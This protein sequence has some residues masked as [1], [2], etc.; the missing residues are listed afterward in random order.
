MAW[1]APTTKTINVSNISTGDWNTYV[2]DNLAALTERP[3]CSLRDAATSDSDQTVMTIGSGTE[4]AVRWWSEEWDSHGLHSTSSARSLVTCPSGWAGVYL[5]CATVSFSAGDPD[6]HRRVRIEVNGSQEWAQAEELPA[7]GS[8]RTT[9]CCIALV[10]MAVGDYLRVLAYQNSGTTLRVLGDVE[11]DELGCQLQVLYMGDSA[12]SSTAFSFEGWG[13]STDAADWWNT[14]VRDSFSRL[15]HRPMVRAAR[16]S[17]SASSVSTGTWTTMTLPSE[18]FDTDSMHS[19]S[20]NTSRITA[21]RKGFYLAF[22]EAGFEGNT[23]GSR[24]VRWAVNGSGTQTVATSPPI[25]GDTFSMQSV[26][27]AFLDASEYLE[28][29]LLQD[30]GGSLNCFAYVSVVWMGDRN[31]VGSAQRIVDPDGWSDDQYAGG[32][33][34]ATVP[35]SW[36]DIHTRDLPGLPFKP[37]TVATRARFAR[38][39]TP[40]EW[41]KVKFNRQQFDPWNLVKGKRNFGEKFVVPQDGVY[42]T[43]S[44]IN[45]VDKQVVA[46]K[47]SV[48]TSTFTVDTGTDVVT[49]TSHG[50]ASG[51]IVNLGTTGSLPGGLAGGEYYARRTSADTLTLHLTRRDAQ[52]GDNIINITSSGSGTHRIS[53]SQIECRQLNLRTGV[54]VRFTTTGTLPSGLVAGTDYYAI[55]IGP[56]KFRVSGTEE[57]AEDN[58]RVP[59]LDS[60]SGTHTV[61]VMEPYGSRGVRLV[62]AGEVQGGWLGSP[63]PSFNSCRPV[64][65][66][67]AAKAEDELWVES[68]TTGPEGSR[69]AANSPN[70]R[71]WVAWSAPFAYTGADP[72][73]DRS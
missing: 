50:F 60:G 56:D 19:T 63:A 8:A 66:I 47:V 58:V 69:I 46:A 73:A 57:G 18:S 24:R 5:V 65:S 41:K 38:D 55:R 23:I 32:A 6:G 68:L 62:H 2:R 64:I 51:A 48:R 13:D 43:G 1:T 53:S 29:Q 61:T 17:G 25:S 42:V 36:V 67:I 45:I 16:G 34:G 11:D 52:R 44:Q 20:T 26:L 33:Q 14:E 37:P 21:Q 7:A 10:D 72:M 22:A 27:F 12:A 54:R 59:L 71:W 15:R 35:L 31:E 40:G 39:I 4:Q 49:A 9:V 70:S 28:L 3:T 30:S